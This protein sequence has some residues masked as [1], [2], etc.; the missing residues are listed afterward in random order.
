M[1]ESNKYSNLTEKQVAILIRQACTAEDWSKILVTDKFDANLVS[2]S[3]FSGIVKI[4]ELSGTVT[5][6]LGN[7]KPSCIYNAIIKNCTIGDNCRITNIGVHIF[8]YHI[9]EGV[10]IENAGTIQANENPS[11]GCG[12]EINVLNEAGNRQV[13]LFEDLT[14]Q[15][16]YMLCIHRYRPKLIEKLQAIADKSVQFTKSKHAV[17]S[18]GVKISSAREIIDVNIGPSTVVRGA[19]SLIN[20]TILCDP[21]S[22]TYIGADVNA[23][24]FI[25]AE[26]A[27]LDTGAV[28]EKVYVG[29]GCRVAKHFTAEHSLFFANSEFYGGEACSVF[30]G[31]YTVTHHKSSLLI[32]GLLS[33][34]NA[35]SGAN[36]SNH[37]YRLGPVHEGKLLRGSKTGSFTYMLWPT[38]TAPFSTVLGKHA[39]AF[40]SSSFPFSTI[41]SAGEQ[42]FI[43]PAIQLES[44]GTLRDG[45]KWPNR[46]KRGKAKRDAISFDVMSPYTVAMVLDAREKLEKMIDETDPLCQT[47]P[48]NS[49]LIKRPDAERAIALYRRN[50]EIYLIEKTLEYRTDNSDNTSGVYS[51]YWADIAGLLMPKGRLEALW[52]KIETGEVDTIEA[53]NSEIR[54]IHQQ[55]GNDQKMWVKGKLKQILNIDPDKITPETVEKLSE[56]LKQLKKEHAEA[57]LVDARKEY[58]QRSKTGYA[59]DGSEN[60]KD[61]DFKQVRGSF[62][63]NNFVK[64]LRK[65]SKS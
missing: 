14:A 12:T 49:A 13:C 48:V 41:Y 24:D 45:L 32:A 36:Q 23:K 40:D 44:S 6:A 2:N 46:D 53:F 5:D 1:T 65:N 25:I 38:L 37:M 52:Q 9:E 28:L 51:D 3:A 54:D 33:F 29:Q 61:E 15:F 19:S 8:G 21:E 11:F 4:G 31:P 57:I 56:R 10:C 62:E 42:T 26:Y 17:I 20:G 58:S 22:P 64:K 63:D 27:S 30:A 35:G 34:F 16:A 55:Y 60:D 18:K 50:A 43:A 59:L 39:Y 7:E 47:I